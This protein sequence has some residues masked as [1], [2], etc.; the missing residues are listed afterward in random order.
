MIFLRGNEGRTK[1]VSPRM[2][3]EMSERGHELR[4]F[5]NDL[6]VAFQ[7]SAIRMRPVAKLRVKDRM[8]LLPDQQRANR[9]RAIRAFWANHLRPSRPGVT[10]RP[11]QIARGGKNPAVPGQAPLQP[12]RPTPPRA[13]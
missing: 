12:R 9:R 5:K 1:L 7:R 13:I 6:P 2:L 10:L 11:G 3:I 4:R 8:R